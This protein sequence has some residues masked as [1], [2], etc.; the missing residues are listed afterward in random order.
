MRY[1]I[2]DVLHEKHLRFMDKQK[3]VFHRFK[4]NIGHSSSKVKLIS[5]LSGNPNKM[6]PR[7]TVFFSDFIV[8]CVS[9][10]GQCARTF[11]KKLKSSLDSEIPYFL[12]ILIL[13]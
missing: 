7:G 12:K 6:M 4:Q 2:I 10:N 5:F 8:E 13:G 1:S 11:F 9:L 3:I